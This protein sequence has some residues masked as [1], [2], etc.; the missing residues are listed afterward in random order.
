MPVNK[1]FH[2]NLTSIASE[3][4]LYKDLIKEQFKYTDMMCITL[5]EQVNARRYS[6]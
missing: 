4:N 3:R 5:T 1:I 6:W 2:D